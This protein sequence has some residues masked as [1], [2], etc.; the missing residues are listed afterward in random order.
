ME[1]FDMVGMFGTDELRSLWV[2]VAVVLLC[3]ARCVLHVQINHGAVDIDNNEFAEFEDVDDIL[4]E[5][6]EFDQSTTQQ[7]VRQSSRTDGATKKPT[8]LQE[9]YEDD[10]LN[11]EDEFERAEKKPE[12]EKGEPQPPQPLKFADVPAHF[13]SNWASYQ[14]EAIVLI[15]LALY[16]INYVLGRSRNQTL[17]YSWFNE[18][19]ALLQQQFALVGDDGTSEEPTEG[20]LVKETD[21]NYSIWCSGRSGCQGMLIQLKLQKRQD[22]I[23]VVMGLARPKQDKAIIRIDVDQNEMDSFVLAFGQRKSVTKAVKEMMDLNVFTVERKG[24][25]RLGL[26]SSMAVF[27]E[28]SEAATAII[29]PAVQ[30][31]VRRYESAID[32]FHFSDQYSGPKPP[33]GETYT[34]LPDTSRVL[35]FAI[36]MG[37]D[38]AETD[39]LMRTVFYCF[40]KIRRGETYTRLPD[41]SRVLIFAINM[42]NDAA[43]TDALMR[44]VF[45]CFEKIRRYRLSREGKLKADKK[46][47]SVQEAFLKTTHQARQEAAQARR[48]EK[49]R[50]RKQ[51]LLEEEDPEKQRRLEKLEMKRDSKMRQPKMKQLKVK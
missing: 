1:R 46:R 28:I 48:E 42:G 33:E 26:P 2:A 6:D 23:S 47:Q 31:V 14:V 15:L 8:S 35:I 30:T 16:M 27:A 11:D 41:T 3:C 24:V 37:N 7:Q 9:E 29:D 12:D 38:A 43:E 45:Y 34:R 20:H 39:A 5:D 17:A 51:R 44:T 25:D 19:T 21:S 4:V 40:E 10:F 32:Y 49:T 13:R 50:E 22:L 36:N 18:V